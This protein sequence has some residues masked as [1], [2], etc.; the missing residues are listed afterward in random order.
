MFTPEEQAQLEEINEKVDRLL[1]SV[2][3]AWDLLEEMLPRRTGV[4]AKMMKGR[5]S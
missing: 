1:D 3:K 4:M 5:K 2:A